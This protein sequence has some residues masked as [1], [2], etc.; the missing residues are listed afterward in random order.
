MRQVKSSR[1]S[2]A[3]RVMTLLKMALREFRSDVASS[4]EAE[5]WMSVLGSAVAEDTFWGTFMRVVKYCGSAGRSV[6][7][8]GTHHPG[9]WHLGDS[10]SLPAGPQPHHSGCHEEIP[11]KERPQAQHKEDKPDGFVSGTGGKRGQVTHHLPSF[12]APGSPGAPE[13]RT[14]MPTSSHKMCAC[15][16][17]HRAQDE[18]EEKG[19]GTQDLSF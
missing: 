13:H 9:T 18:L 11:G 3:H 1:G 2:M 12:P 19:S 4:G 10:P 15:R 8:Q 7:S 5:A 14:A 16:S 6:G 17:W